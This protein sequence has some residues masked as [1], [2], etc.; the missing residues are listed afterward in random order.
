M[1]YFNGIPYFKFMHNKTEN[2]RTKYIN[3]IPYFK[4]MHNKTDSNRRKYINGIPY[5]KCLHNE[6]DRK[7]HPTDRANIYEEHTFLSLTSTKD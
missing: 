1:R 5:F 7:K 4:F 3:G 2:N 6:N